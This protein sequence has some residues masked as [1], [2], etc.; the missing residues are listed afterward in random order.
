VLVIV[1]D[2]DNTNWLQY[3][4]E[5][6]CRINKTNFEISITS[7]TN[8]HT[9][10]NHTISYQRR[11]TGNNSIPNLCGASLG[12][13]IFLEENLFIFKGTGSHEN[14]FIPFDIFWN[15]FAILSRLEEFNNERAGKLIK[16]YS[17]K[18]PRIDKSTFQLPIV[19]I[20]FNLLESKITA[21]FPDLTFG[22][23][24]EPVIELSHD[25]DYL[26]KTP[27]LRLKQTVFNTIN[28]LKSYNKP[29]KF[30]RQLYK[31]FG[32]FFTN[33]T[34]WCFDYWLNVEARYNMKS[35]FYIYAK[36]NS[37]NIKSWLIDPSY[38]ISS[39]K[40]L[41]EKLTTMLDH[42]TT[43]GLHGSLYSAIDKE[44]MSREKEILET[45]LACEVT[46]NRQHW[47][48]YHESITPFIHDDLFKFDSTIGWND[49]PGFRA[50]IGS[51]FRH[52]NHLEDKP[53]NY[54]II[55]QVLMDSHLF[56][57]N[58]NSS[59][60]NEISSKIIDQVFHAKTG[61]ISLSWHP[62]TCSPDYNW[63]HEY[64]RILNYLES[65]L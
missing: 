44:Q 56:D 59:S 34:Y 52:Y 35:V 26:H 20:Y 48:N 50:G 61:Y 23:K 32:F 41:V 51:K 43:I 14:H 2:N 63:H 25:L 19:N 16:S 38:D 64:E 45:Q 57:Y 36:S 24:D 10:E 65:R 21:K 28:T 4:I 60:A 6:F 11:S 31:T 47:L 9:N 54:K 22:K 27:Q 5:E 42:E 12:E 15:A 1:T 30:V 46:R 58:N 17:S 7:V 18:H 8:D 55:P 49:I 39:N 62:R 33:S 3:I 13:V 29:K 53:F 37:R 40:D